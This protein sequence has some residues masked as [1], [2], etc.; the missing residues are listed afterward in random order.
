MDENHDGKVTIDE[1][2]DFIKN[3]NELLISKKSIKELKEN[4]VLKYG[5]IDKNKNKIISIDELCDFVANDLAK[6]INI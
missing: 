1:F 3:D 5:E 2:R 4:V 6:N